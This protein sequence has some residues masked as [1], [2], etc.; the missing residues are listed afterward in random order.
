MSELKEKV[1]YLQ[2]LAA[3][4]DIDK[5]SKEG[6][7][8]STVIDVLNEITLTIEE[9]S[10][11]QKEFENYLEAL[12]EDLGDM[13]DDIYGDD[14]DDEYDDDD[15]CECDCECDCDC[16]DEECDCNFVELECP[17]CHNI[18]HYESSILDNDD[19]IEVSC[20]NCNEVIYLNDD[21]KGKK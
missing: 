15:D 16:N 1:A 8:F 21:D 4:L 11:N 2:G 18:V 7:M 12:D 14:D 19:V 20:P 17:K 13:E 6:K 10:T 3:G 5:E 9:V